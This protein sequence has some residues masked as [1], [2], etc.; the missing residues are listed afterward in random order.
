MW[1][2]LWNLVKDPRSRCS[3][4]CSIAALSC[5][6]ILTNI[7]LASCSG[8]SVASPLRATRK[9]TTNAERFFF[10]LWV[11]WAAKR[12]L[13]YPIVPWWVEVSMP[14]LIRFGPN[15]GAYGKVL[16]KLIVILYTKGIQLSCSFQWS[17]FR[18]RPGGSA[19]YMSMTQR[20][21][22]FTPG[23]LF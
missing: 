13:A 21:N 3:Q 11:C 17:M 4:Y 18:P 15:W 5:S 19:T 23:T 1:R 16:I 2:V 10:Y 22:L 20:Y 14:S 6:C 12:N 8:A 7:S 9:T